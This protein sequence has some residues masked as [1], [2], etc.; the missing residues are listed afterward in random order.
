MAGRV[1]EYGGV[2]ATEAVLRWCAFF[3]VV[4]WRWSYRSADLGGFAPTFQVTIPALDCAW[5]SVR[6][7]TQIDLLVTEA[8]RDLE[9]GRFEGL[10]LGLGPHPLGPEH[11]GAYA[12]Y[13]KAAWAPL[14]A[15]LAGLTRPLRQLWREALDGLSHRGGGV[16]SGFTPEK[17]GGTTLPDWRSRGE[18]LA[19]RWG[20]PEEVRDWGLVVAKIGETDELLAGVLAGVDKAEM[21][22]EHLNI[23]LPA[24]SIRTAVLRSM[25]ADPRRVLETILNVQLQVMVSG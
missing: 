7:A 21:L 18:A 8:R 5:V 10:A 6:R 23:W 17:F 25:G 20:T 24:H 15:E 4:G 14:T 11:L 19:R 2:R 13:P 16:D 3:D 22:A 9:R 1:Y 12:S